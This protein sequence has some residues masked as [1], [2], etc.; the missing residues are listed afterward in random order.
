M[1]SHNSRLTASAKEIQKEGTLI[2]L[3]DPDHLLGN[4][5]ASATHAADSQEDVIVEEISC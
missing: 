2:L 1:V 4:I 5:F 3:L